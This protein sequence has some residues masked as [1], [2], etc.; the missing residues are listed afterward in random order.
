LLESKIY[1]T[2][3]FLSGMLGIFML[4]QYWQPVTVAKSILVGF[5]AGSV[6]Y[7]IW[8]ISNNP[9]TWKGMLSKFIPKG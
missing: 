7:N 3:T 6:I 1:L 4:Q 5:V 2:I 8:S 9:D